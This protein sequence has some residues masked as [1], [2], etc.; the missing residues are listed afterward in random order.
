MK[1]YKN[2]KQSNLKYHILFWTINWLF[3]SILMSEG[4][5]LGFYLA[6]NF[7]MIQFQ[8]LIFYFNWFVLFPQFFQKKKYIIYI[9]TS[10]ASVYFVFVFSFSWI[11]INLKIAE[12]IFP[13]VHGIKF[14][15]VKFKYPFWVILSNSA[16]YSLSLMGSLV[17]KIYQENKKNKTLA[18]E[19]Q[20]QQSKTEIQ[21]LRSQISPHFL[22]NSLNN[23][24]SLI[25]IDAKKGSDYTITLSNLLRYMLYEVKKERTELGNEIKGLNDYLDL[26]EMKIEDSNQK[27]VLI[28][29]EHP[30]VQIVPLLLISLVENG[31]KHSGIEYDDA[32]WIELEIVEK[33]KKLELQLKNSVLTLKS[34]HSEKG[35]GFDNLQKRLELNY[36]QQYTFSF[37]I[38]KNIA[39]TKLT[40]NLLDA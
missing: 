12:S 38:E 19:L 31:I 32:S 33:N 39:T 40:L 10:L 14:P 3:Q 1:K 23:I 5:H 11:E 27:K 20:L 24:H 7:A 34:N 25:L 2:I 13:S 18:N 37:A 35:I 8:M 26:V 15:P 9:L 16:P 28:Q 21:Y 36:S 17:L 30:D 29:I 4:E 6:K 22:F